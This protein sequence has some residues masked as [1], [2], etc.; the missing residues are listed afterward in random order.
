[1]PQLELRLAALVQ[2]LSDELLLAEALLFPGASCLHDRSARLHAMLGQRIREIVKRLPPGEIYRCRLE[3]LPTLAQ[4]QVEVPP[5]RG[6]YLRREPVTLTFHYVQWRHGND[7]VIAAIPALGIEVLAEDQRQIDEQLVPQIRSALARRKSAASLRDL[8]MLGNVKQ[9]QVKRLR[10]KVKLPTLKQAAQQELAEDDQRKS[11]LKQVGTDLNR[12]S[13]RPVYERDD[14][15]ARLAKLLTARSP[16]SVL[17]VGPSGA[18]KTALV[19]ELARRRADFALASTPL[20]STSGSRLVAGMSGFG[21]WQERCQKLVREA[22]KTHAIVHLDNLVELIETGKGGGNTQGIA[23]VLRPTIARGSLLAIAEC[24]P[25]QLAIIE[26]EDP[27]LLEAFVQLEIPEPTPDQTRSIL[28]RVAAGSE[29]RGEPV[30]SG[31]ALAELDRLHRRYAGYSAAPGRHL[32]FLA[33]LLEDRPRNVVLST[34][35]VTASFSHETGLPLFMLDDT[36]PFDLAATRAWFADRVIGQAEPVEL[37][38]NLLAAVK[39]GLARGGKP[40]ASLLF[41]GPT[42]VGKTEMA[43]SLAEFLY[44]DP[45]RMTRFDMSEYSHPAAVERLIGGAYATHG[46]LTQKVRDQPFMVVLLDEFEKAHPS[47]FDVLLQVLGEGRLTDGAGRVADFTNSVVIMTSN[48]GAESFRRTTAGFADLS[49]GTTAV[50]HFERHVKAFL[51]PEMFNRLDRIVPFAP[52]SPE[53]ITRIARRE[54]DGLSRRDG[55]RMR[56]IKLEIAA[57]AVEH[58]AQ[59]GYDPRYGARPLKRAIERHLVAPLAER[60]CRNA[61]NG[62]VDFR[63]QAV[64]GQLLVETIATSATRGQ[65][66]GEEGNPQ[67]VL[68][69]NELLNLR[70][71]TQALQRSGTVLRL[72]NELYRLQ[73]AQRQHRRNA[74][75]LRKEAGFSFTAEHRRVLA[76]EGLLQ[77]IDDLERDVFALEDSA[78]DEFYTGKLIDVAEVSQ[79]RMQLDNRLSEIMFELYVAQNESRGILTLAIFGAAFDRVLQ[80]VAAYQHLCAGEQVNLN[81]YWLKM[82]N[83]ALD[84]TVGRSNLPKIPP[85]QI[86]VL[87][88]LHRK[89]AA[90]EVQ[91]K[92]IDI[93]PVMAD[94]FVSPPSGAIGVAMELQG[95]RAAALLET[96]SGRHEFPRLA[97]KPEVCYVE[98]VGNLLRKYEPP[99]DAGRATAFSDLQLRRSYDLPHE[100]CRDP[101]LKEQFQIVGRSIDRVVVEV[102]AAYLT[103]RTWNLVD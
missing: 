86:P 25:E 24:V 31:T 65:V 29:R 97:G 82:Y 18:G 16:Q 19:H 46:L 42:G 102:T 53:I 38:T 56:D 103:K 43:K 22:E 80:L 28:V 44:Q 99:V 23:S 36:A 3:Q 67:V 48:L 87:R 63:V 15:L 71:Q 33:N 88:L 98:A 58:L 8:V 35:D 40:L 32:R 12:L 57:E 95:T 27:Q 62:A 4:V 30:I 76:Q 74:K 84:D 6:D 75:R 37:L 78:L 11:V 39:T 81:C 10:I 20:W 41:I 66:K 59:G 89:Q 17:L 61:G 101:L 69:L 94:Q 13:S 100:L 68:R 83:P 1:M 55:L 64:E 79:Q 73:Q 96:E 77:R 7:A 60:L 52:L 50:G 72:R 49:S 26:R 34:A 54:L 21:M 90:D 14:L 92:V 91:N 85:E 2:T 45:G 9:L 47:L 5:L 51:R 93:F 70:R